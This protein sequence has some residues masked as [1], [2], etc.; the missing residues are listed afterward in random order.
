MKNYFDILGISPEASEE[1]IKKA[2]R[3]L[4]MK[5]HPDRGGDQTK[6]QE[7]Q[8]AYDILSDPQK[9]AEW[10]MMR[11]GGGNPFAHP[12]AHPGGFHFNFNFTPGADPF[13]IHEVFRNMHNGAGPFGGFGPQGPQ[14]HVRK[15]RDLRV[16]I[17]LDLVS[18][19]EKQTKHISVKHINGRRE[20]V[21]VEIPRGVTGNMQMKYAG[22]GDRS[23]ADLPPG[24][25]YINFRV[26]THPDFIIEGIDLIRVVKLNCIDAITGTTVNITGLDGAEFSVNVPVGTQNNTRFK[27][28]HQGLYSLEH[29]HRGNLMLHVELTVPNNLNTEQLLTLERISQELKQ[30]GKQV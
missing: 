22:Y 21:T 15:N 20:T 12:G 29:P 11:Q 6:F 24:D 25:L 3:S 30:S 26:H 13:D 8:E 16:A 7:I 14:Q 1:D 27:I 17:D 4:A 18:T 5:H 10:N 19:L 2:Y 9:K 28:G 23:Q